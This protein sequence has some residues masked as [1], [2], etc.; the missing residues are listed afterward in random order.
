MNIRA[1]AD[2]RRVGEFLG[3]GLYRLEHL[4]APFAR[5][6]GRHHARQIVQHG[7]RC[8]E[9]AEIL[10]RDS[11]ARDLA[12]EQIHLTRRDAPDRAVLVAKLEKPGSGNRAQHGNRRGKPR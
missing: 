3:G 4:L 5:A 2:G 10:E 12:Q 6:I 7:G 1:P 11:A 8:A 9:G